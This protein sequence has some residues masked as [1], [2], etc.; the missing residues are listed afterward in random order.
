M[1]PSHWPSGQTS[2]TGKGCQSSQPPPAGQLA[3][4]HPRGSAPPRAGSP[5][6][7]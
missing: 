3:S 4:A 7:I 2:C 1:S 5:K 6:C